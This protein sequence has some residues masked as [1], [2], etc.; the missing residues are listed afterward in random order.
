MISS[1]LL[2]QVTFDENDSER[3]LNAFNTIVEIN[4]ALKKSGTTAAKE[5]SQILHEAQSVLL[6][7]MDGVA[8]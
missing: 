2:V 7:I 1:E 6:K 3:I 4:D 8:F 5:A